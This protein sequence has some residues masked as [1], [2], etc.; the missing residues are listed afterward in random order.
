VVLCCVVCSQ[1]SPACSSACEWLVELVICG[2]DTA[3][4]VFDENDQDI[5]RLSLSL[6]TGAGV[7]KRQG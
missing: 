4:G 1:R 5:R 7:M 3:F 6:Q 2:V